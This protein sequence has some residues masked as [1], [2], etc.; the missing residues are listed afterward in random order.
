MLNEYTLQVDTVFFIVTV[1][2]IS[3]QSFLDQRFVQGKTNLS[4]GN[5]HVQASRQELTSIGHD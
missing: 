1:G 4:H 2:L 5:L 3:L